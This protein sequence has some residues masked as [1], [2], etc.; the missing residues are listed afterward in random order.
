M[1]M[2]PFPPALR[3]IAAANT[4]AEYEARLAQRRAQRVNTPSDHVSLQAAA[5]R[6]PNGAVKPAYDLY[7]AEYPEGAEP[8]LADMT[9]RVKYYPNDTHGYQTSCSNFAPAPDVLSEHGPWACAAAAYVRQSGA[10][11]GSGTLY[12]APGEAALADMLAAAQVADEANIDRPVVELTADIG[13]ESPGAIAYGGVRMGG[14]HSDGRCGTVYVGNRPAEIISKMMPLVR[15]GMD[16]FEVAAHCTTL[17]REQS[18][19][20]ATCVTLKDQVSAGFMATDFSRVE[21]GHV[22]PDV[23][24]APSP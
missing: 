17:E 24:E 8:G 13:T 22:D 11:A 18:L 2:I 23:E 15:N 9:H 12:L 16:E 21:I 14:P 7:N 19:L 6:L 5:Y 10:S 3:E 1:K 4:S 20:E